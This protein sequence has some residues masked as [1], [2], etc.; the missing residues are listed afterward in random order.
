MLI[1]LQCGLWS[2]VKRTTQAPRKAKFKRPGEA[3]GLPA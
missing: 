1:G 3:D 2:Y